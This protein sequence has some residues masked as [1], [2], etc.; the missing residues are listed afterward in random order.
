[1]TFTSTQRHSLAKRLLLA[2]AEPF[3]RRWALSGEPSKVKANA[4]RW[5]VLPRLVAQGRSY[6]RRFGD[7]EFEGDTRDSLGKYVYLFGTWQPYLSA[8]VR[9]RARKD[10]VFV[11]VGA[12]TGWFTLQALAGAVVAIEASPQIAERLHANLDRNKANNVRVVVAAVWSSR[13]TLGIDDGPAEDTGT[14]SVCPGNAIPCDTLQ[15]LLTSDELVKV[16]LVKID[17]EGAEQ[18]VV[19]GL[20]LDCFPDDS[21]FVVEIRGTNPRRPAVARAVQRKN[22][23]AVFSAF[24][25]YNAFLV[26]DPYNV[27]HYLIEPHPISLPRISGVNGMLQTAPQGG[28]VLFSRHESVELRESDLIAKKV[29]TRI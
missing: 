26:P 9:S 6:R 3:V 20:D 13:G 24:S 10:R 14:T 17:V 7:I 11:D 25:D 1:M 2:P 16:R 12:H 19:R 27:S 4:L 21:E 22:A 18:E 29:L 15:G 28:D 8:L 23:D 5:L